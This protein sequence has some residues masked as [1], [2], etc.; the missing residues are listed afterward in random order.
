MKKRIRILPILVILLTTACFGLAFQSKVADIREVVWTK[1][2]LQN[3]SE[4]IGTWRDATLNKVICLDRFY[5]KY[6]GKEIYSVEFQSTHD[7]LLGPVIVYVDPETMEII[8]VPP[9]C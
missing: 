7:A 2:S 1:L 4:I 8:G 3:R 5:P 6:L 9:R